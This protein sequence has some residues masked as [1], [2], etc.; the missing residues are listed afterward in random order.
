MG[1]ADA[2]PQAQMSY[3]E[4][5][6]CLQ[7]TVLAPVPGAWI[8][9]KGYLQSTSTCQ[10][11]TQPPPPKE[12]EEFE[13]LKRMLPIYRE[14]DAEKTSQSRYSQIL[15]SLNSSFSALCKSRVL[16]FQTI[17]LSNYTPTAQIN[18]TEASQCLMI[19]KNRN[20]K[21]PKWWYNHIM[22]HLMQLLK[23]GI[24]HPDK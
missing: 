19:V 3:R 23:H 11:H 21:C 22:E 2:A 13:P 20:N 18:C 15:Y 7:R 8:Q 6:Y 17:W 24:F 9:S 1:G 10:G 14:K 5:W 16:I 4:A 12:G